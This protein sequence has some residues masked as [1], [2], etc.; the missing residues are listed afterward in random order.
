M[1]ENSKLQYLFLLLLQYPN[2]SMHA[3][4]YH[5]VWKDLGNQTPAYSLGVN[6]RGYS[7]L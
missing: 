2:D 6:D 4:S 1:D 3:L 7:S 5:S